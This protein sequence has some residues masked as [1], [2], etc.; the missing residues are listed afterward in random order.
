MNSL[1]FIFR[2]PLDVE[3]E[4]LILLVHQTESSILMKDYLEVSKTGVIKL[5]HY[6]EQK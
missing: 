2:A 6:N 3:V 1:N 5:K 4:M